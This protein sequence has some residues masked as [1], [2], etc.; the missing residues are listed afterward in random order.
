[1]SFKDFINE[2][3]SYESDTFSAEASKITRDEAD[4]VV[5][6]VMEWI[7]NDRIDGVLLSEALAEVRGE[8]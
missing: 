6:K 3:V 2:V 1:M 7:W 8:E 4:A 5:L